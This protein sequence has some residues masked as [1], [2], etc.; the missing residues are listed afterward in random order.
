MTRLQVAQY[1]GVHHR[2]PWLRCVLTTRLSTSLAIPTR[3]LGEL[4]R[5]YVRVLYV[6]ANDGLLVY[7]RAAAYSLSPALKPFRQIYAKGH[8]ARWDNPII[9]ISQCFPKS[10]LCLT[11]ALTVDVASL[12]ACI[13]VLRY[14]TA[15]RFA[16]VYAS[17]CW[18]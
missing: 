10:F 11:L 9:S 6:A 18:H 16:L 15:I 8:F 2:Q 14:P 1:V 13:L 3:Q 5:A 12:S 4:L 17:L 7:L